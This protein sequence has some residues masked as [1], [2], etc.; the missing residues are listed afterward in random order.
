ML[1]VYHNKTSALWGDELLYSIRSV[2]KYYRG[3][4]DLLV[5]GDIPRWL[6]G[7]GCVSASHFGS[8]EETTG[9]NYRLIC[10]M[11]D[12]RDDIVIMNDDIYL[13]NEV[14]RDTLTAPCV[15]HDLAEVS[16]DR[17]LSSRWGRLLW[18][19]YD[20]CVELGV[21]TYNYES[22]S[23]YLINVGRLQSCADKFDLFDG[24]NLLA[25]SY[26]N[27]HKPVASVSCSRRFGVYK[28]GRPV[29][30]SGYHRWL[31]HSDGGFTRDLAALI[32]SMYP[33]KCKFE[34]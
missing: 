34:A 28:A 27:Y 30:L 11:I 14:T 32:R 19:T 6:T 33:D 9:R 20:R 5:I 31:N 1:F 24:R 12:H 7:A 8:P 3:K 13:V 21:S 16:V 2:C 26:Y 10:D 18:A 4:V 22:H 25:T 29:K 17:R 15:L 23:P